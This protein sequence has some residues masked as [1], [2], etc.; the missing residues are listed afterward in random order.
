VLERELEAACLV[1]EQAMTLAAVVQG[2]TGKPA[3]LT[4]SDL[5]PVTV[6]DFAVQ[7]QVCRELASRFPD[8]PIVGEEDSAALH[9]A[10]RAPLVEQIL[11][12]L[13]AAGG[14]FDP[15]SLFSAIDLGNG[16][17][18]DRFW[19]LDP[20]DG[21]KGFLRGEQYAVAL[22]LIERGQVVLG[23]LGCPRF[24]L[25]GEDSDAGG[26]LFWAIR[27]EGAYA[28]DG[29]GGKTRRLSLPAI[30]RD[31]CPVLAHSYESNHCDHELQRE[32]ARTLGIT[33][34]P[35]AIDSQVKYGAVAAGRADIYL[36]IPSRLHWTYREK[37]WD[38]AAGSLIVTEAG[39][40][41]SDIHGHP[42][43]FTAGTALLRNTGI[44]ACAPGH[45]RP[46]L[47]ALRRHLPRD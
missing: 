18:G 6:A 16:H 23:A 40:H 3:A 28:R 34:P 7:A 8:L 15:A 41:S 12:Q 38:H 2:Q 13:A 17:P 45:A 30:T 25:D 44:L 39:G 33:A 9:S 29:R 20:I 35:L 27:G 19:A 21:T 22:A 5:S 36:R 47:D 31:E 46:V 42:L 1:V 32:V 4:K 14:S 11:A 10:E 37:I 24:S 43:D 26:T